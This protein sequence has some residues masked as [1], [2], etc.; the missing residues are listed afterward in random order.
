MEVPFLME[1]LHITG[2]IVQKLAFESALP[3]KAAAICGLADPFCAQPSRTQ[4]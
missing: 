3:D 1:M 4:P 2:A